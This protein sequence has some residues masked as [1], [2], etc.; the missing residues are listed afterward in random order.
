M[1][2]A[3]YTICYN[4]IKRVDRWIE[5]T[6]DFDYRVVLDTGSTDG[7]YEILKK[8]PGIILHQMRK[9]PF[10]FHEHRNF[11]LNMV[12]QDVEWCLSPDID[13]WFSINVLEEIE[14]TVQKHPNVTNIATT[15]LDLYT[16]KVFVGPPY[17]IPTNKIHRR[18]MYVWK[19]PIYEHLCY[20]GP[21]R[22]VEIYND[23]VFLIHD[24]D[25]SKPR[26][27]VYG[28]MLIE[29]YQEDPTDNWNNWFLLNHYYREKQLENYIEVAV[30]YCKFSDRK[31]D[32]YTEVYQDLMNIC[33]YE[34]KLDVR[35][36]Q[37]ILKEI[38]SI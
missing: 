35:L 33:Q 22:E 19:A 38:Q 2:T 6:K 8:V 9:E 7:T 16:K 28:A 36:R 21:G 10:K 25:T 31:D 11:N 14:K 13:E 37:A 30:N 29:R 20:T 32:K 26:D 3:A 34:M 23:M 27:R 24:Q 18:H 1:K 15:R 4:E 17:S 12:P 5:Y